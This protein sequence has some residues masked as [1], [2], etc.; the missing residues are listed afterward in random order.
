MLEDDIMI[1]CVIV[2]NYPHPNN[3]SIVLPQYNYSKSKIVW[4]IL[5]IITRVNAVYGLLDVICSYRRWFCGMP[6][7]FMCI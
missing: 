2:L 1:Y 4:I 5:D 3:T 7:P 6:C